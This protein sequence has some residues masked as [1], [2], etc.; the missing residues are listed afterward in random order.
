MAD[1]SSQRP[2]AICMQKSV[3]DAI[4]LEDVNLLSIFKESR[5][6]WFLIM[7]AK[8]CCMPVEGI[9]FSPFFAEISLLF[10]SFCPFFGTT[11]SYFF[12]AF[13]W[14]AGEALGCQKFGPYLQIVINLVQ[15]RTK[16][17]AVHQPEQNFLINGL[18][19]DWGIPI[20]PMI[21]DIQ[22]T[23]IDIYICSSAKIIAI[24]LMLF[25]IS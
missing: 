18:F 16:F 5:T 24:C 10:P 20:E 8:S 12:A 15:I 7:L 19:L 11:S 14:K 22:L 23:K 21:T 6:K 13:C 2:G 17:P 9:I 1:F 25:K 4:L 3:S